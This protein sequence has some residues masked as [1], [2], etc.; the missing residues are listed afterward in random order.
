MQ[1]LPFNGA[2]GLTIF[3]ALRSILVGFNV[4]TNPSSLSILAVGFYDDTSVFN[5]VAFL[6]DASVF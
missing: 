4:I 2:K 6:V 3:G 1:Y 5:P